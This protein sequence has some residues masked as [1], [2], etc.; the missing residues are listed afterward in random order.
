[1]ICKQFAFAWLGRHLSVSHLYLICTRSAHDLH[2]IWHMLYAW[3]ARDLYVICTQFVNKL[4]MMPRIPCTWSR[5]WS[6]YNVY[7][8]S[9]IRSAPNLHTICIWC[10]IIHTWSVCNW[11][12]TWS[13]G[14]LNVILSDLNLI[15]L[16]FACDLHL[17]CTWSA[18]DLHII[19]TSSKEPDL[20]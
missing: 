19:W 6:A 15:C 4:H 20:I 10:D 16:A 18:C 14:D 11:C 7:L 3:S 12:G 17:M 2:C 8:M 9:G 1:M 13:S 5:T